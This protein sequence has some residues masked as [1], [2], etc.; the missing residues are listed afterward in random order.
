MARKRLFRIQFHNHGKVYQIYARRVTQGNLYGFV[1][2]EELVFEEPSPL[3]I[4]P[5][6]ERLKSEFEGVR[7][8]HL[9]L[10][11]VI[12]ID[13]VEKRGA[14]RILELDVPDSNVIPYPFA[15]AGAPKKSDS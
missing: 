11:A 4:D 7:V 2:V 15:P 14:A 3:V 8:V 13:E 10:H 12:R 1:E 5:S 9:P 6:E